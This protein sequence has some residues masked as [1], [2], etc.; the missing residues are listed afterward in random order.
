MRRTLL[1]L[2]AALCLLF[3]VQGCA[4][5]EAEGEVI[6]VYYLTD[7][8]IS[9]SR[10]A[11][12][13]VEV[14]V[15]KYGDKV[16]AAMRA[17]LKKPDEEGLISPFV[18]GTKLRSA[19]LENGQLTIA[20]S[21]EYAQL[22]GAELA[23]ADACAVLTLCALDEVREV[24]L[25][26]NGNPHPSKGSQFISADNILTGV[27]AQ[28]MTEQEITLYYSDGNLD[29]V[30]PEVRNVVVRNIS[31]IEEYVVEELIKGPGEK[32]HQRILP[33]DLKLLGITREGRI[34][35]VN[36]SRDFLDLIHGSRQTEIQVLYSV[37][38]TLCSIEGIEGIQYL[39]EGKPLYGKSVMLPEP[40]VT[41]AY[42]D[43]SVDVMLY[44]TDASGESLEPVRTRIE[45][46]GGFSM[47]QLIV[48]R[49]ITG[50]DGNGFLS[51]MPKGTMVLGIEQS[52]ETCRINFSS[53]FIQNNTGAVSRAQLIQ[54]LTRSLSE[55]I[56]DIKQVQV[57]V[58]GVKYAE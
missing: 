52:G 23:A 56:D 6:Q 15:P 38:N 33:E 55:N 12:Q 54:I 19:Q 46:T 5:R 32:G 10:E 2:F 27:Q 9:A 39:V 21:E 26:V 17:L 36:F 53:E 1:H 16:T 41:S 35:M 24:L 25:T 34:C 3:L 30:V 51:M 4:A 58:N 28:S 48:E 44:M 43:T 13:A 45:T 18:Q 8:E 11:V 57:Y 7:L 42:S 31:S 20:L 40:L 14:P 37:T 50:L 47:A 49:I 29:Y 22:Y